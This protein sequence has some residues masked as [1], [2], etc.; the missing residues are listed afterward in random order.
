MGRLLEPQFAATALALDRAKSLRLFAFG[1]FTLAMAGC[2]ATAPQGVGGGSG[3]AS[4]TRVI[5]YQDTVTVE[6]SDRSLCTG[7]RSQNGP[8]WQGRLSGC[9]H[10]W[11][12]ELR[13]PPGR[14][15]RLPLAKGAG[16]AGEVRLSPPG[17]EAEIWSG[18]GP[19]L[20]G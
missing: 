8:A 18:G 11:P 17:R 5:L 14:F 3:G 19:R 10:L 2:V 6:M 16:G 12:Y 20:G 13:Q 1:T 7:P 9:R 4:V 15:V